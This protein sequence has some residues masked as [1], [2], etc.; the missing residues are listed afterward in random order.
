M[1]KNTWSYFKARG[2]QDTR[3]QKQFLEAIYYPH[4]LV[5]GTDALQI[6]W[7]AYFRLLSINLAKFTSRALAIFKQVIRVGLRLWFS[8]KLIIARLNP[9]P[10]NK[11]P[12]GVLTEQVFE[13]R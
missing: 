13:C 7:N 5:T 2:T 4:T 3:R 12:N 8:T 10:T 1:D 11:N 6:W 9:V